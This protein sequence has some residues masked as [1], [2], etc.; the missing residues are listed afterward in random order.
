MKPLLASGT[1][2]EG[3][4]YP[5]LASPKLDGVR[6][7]IVDGVA[8]S[9]NMKPIPNRHVQELFGRKALNGLD[10]ELVVGNPTSPQ[11]FSTTMSGVM[12]VEGKPEVHFWIFDAIGPSPFQ[13]RLEFAVDR[14]WQGGQGDGLRVVEHELI[15]SR[16]ELD[17]YEEKQV[18][19]GYEG[20]MLRDPDGVYKQ[21][22]STVKEGILMKVKRFDD[23][24]AVILGGVPLMRNTNEAVK[25]EL[26][27][28]KRSN[29][30]AGKVADAMLGAFQVRDLKT[31]IEFE[32]G[33]GFNEHQRRTYW[34]KLDKLLGLTI[35]YKFQPSG[36]KEKPRF[37]VFKGFRDPRDV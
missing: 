33:S 14:V 15:R 24:E 19:L 26:G 6:C 23:S 7:L 13:R 25:D 28:T 36:V 31:G 20:I 2:L 10:G 21:G 11:C 27:R 3:L 37:P 18:Q 12:S 16:E 8:M 29:A 5:V 30:K 22:R 34:G 4:R 17:D 32:I 9:R 1:C 35:T